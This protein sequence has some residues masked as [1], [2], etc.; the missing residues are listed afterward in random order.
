MPLSKVVRGRSTAVHPILGR[1]GGV[2]IIV[3]PETSTGDY[4]E[5]IIS[6]ADRYRLPT[7]YPFRVFVTAGGLMFLWG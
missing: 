7:I 3:M 6:L 2:G 4:G 5:A 1:E